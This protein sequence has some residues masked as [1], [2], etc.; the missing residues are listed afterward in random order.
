[1]FYLSFFIPIAYRKPASGTAAN[2]D[3]KQV[4][5]VEKIC[6]RHPFFDYIFKIKNKK[7]AHRKILPLQSIEI[8]CGL[9]INI[10]IRN[11]TLILKKA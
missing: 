7:N 3:V 9:S 10:G 8:P 11:K 6:L 4:S 1:L 5:Q 2:K